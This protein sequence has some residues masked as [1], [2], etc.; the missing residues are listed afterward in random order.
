MKTLLSIG[1]GFSARALG[2]RLI[3]EGWKVIGT[4][5]SEDKA[6]TLRNLTRGD[7][8]DVVGD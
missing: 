6:E 1:H 8:G 7:S 5:R 2:Q 4:T 3:A